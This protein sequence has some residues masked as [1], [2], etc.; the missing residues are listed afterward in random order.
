MRFSLEDAFR[1]PTPDVLRVAQAVED[2]GVDRVG[3]ADTVGCATP[4]EVTERIALLRGAVACDIEFH[5]HNDGA[6]A[7]ANAW[8][9]WRAG[10]TH[11]DTTV[12]GIGERNGIASLGGLIARA[13]QSAPETVERF[14][15]GGLAALDAL[16]A[17]AVGVEVPFS[18]CIT[19]PTAFAHK[20]GMHAKAVLADPSSY[21]SLDPARFGLEREVLLGHT[22]VGRHGLAARAASL[23]LELVG[24]P[25]ADATQRL[26]SLA[27]GGQLT[28]EC[29]D[30]VLR[31]HAVPMPIPVP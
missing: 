1:T 9:A 8:A 20:A 29:V 28:P 26:K 13:C 18:A 14:E 31:S 27:D 24:A 16:V 11:L 19:G 10:A 4:D 2:L 3:V 12:L 5:G 15:L 21:E 22:L 30:A 25:L 7:V 23:G 6:C 17:S